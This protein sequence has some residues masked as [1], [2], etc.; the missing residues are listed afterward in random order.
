MEQVK[1]EEYSDYQQVYQRKVKQQ[2]DRNKQY[3]LLKNY[4]GCKQCGSKEVDAYDL[5][6]EN[7]LV[8]Q[9]CLMRKKGSSSSPINFL[10]QERWYKRFWKI[11]LAEWLETYNCLP[12]NA[13]CAKKWLKDK[14][15][16]DNCQCLELEAKGHYLLVNDNL[17]R[18]WEKLKDCQCETSPKVRVSNDNYAWCERCEVGIPAASKKRV[19][20]NRNDPRFWG[21]NV[22]EKVLCGKCLEKSKEKMTPLRRAKFNEY[23]KLGRL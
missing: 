18:S 20:K 15:H 3:Q 5:Y 2:K 19:I 1:A 7:R 8:C 4:Q 14:K 16:L 10:E 9:P 11:E 13:E 23:R 21:L 6:E 12:V 17:K 22:K